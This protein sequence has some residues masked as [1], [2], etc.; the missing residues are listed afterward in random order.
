MPPIIDFAELDLRGA[1]DFAILIEEDAQLRYEQLSRLLGDDPGGAGDVFR[2]M[3]A[4]EGKHRTDLVARRSA[5]FAGEPA[6][7]EI[8]VMD[9]GPERPDVDDA[10]LPRTA[11][12][13]L[14]LS[15]AAERH[16]YDFYR[17]ALPGL[18]DEAARAFFRHLMDEE[19]EHE[20]VL[21]AKVAELDARSPAGAPPPV[22]VPAAPE[23]ARESLPDREELAAALPHFD[24]ATRA[25]VRSVLVEGMPERD[26][27]AALGVSRRSIARKVD[28]FLGIAR[29]HVALAAATAA[30]AGCGSVQSTGHREGP[31]GLDVSPVAMHAPGEQVQREDRGAVARRVRAEVARHM[32]GYDSATH[33]RITRTILAE[34]KAANLDPLLVLAVIHVESMFDPDA[35]SPVGA[36]GLMQLLEPTMEEELKRTGHEKA[37]PNDPIA[38]VKAGVRYLRRMVKK[39]GEVDVAL[40]AYNAGP[41]RIVQ[42]L[43]DQGAIPERFYEYPER[44]NRELSRLRV[45][46]DAAELPTL[47]KGEGGDG[48]DAA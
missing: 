37:E 30:L 26:V 7:I 44:V 20:A 10:D 33:A 18:R 34:A 31:R 42:Y 22:L 25:V 9:E 14:L 8:S 13:A 1:L 47:S 11:R 3:I 16:A 45:A 38:N 32:P 5:L 19:L 46:L 24:A 12:E 15:A 23:P 36:V 17:D 4:T 28:R 41:G 40:M 2:M 27:A 6:R 48:A 35:L 29:R 39:F 21:L 43:R